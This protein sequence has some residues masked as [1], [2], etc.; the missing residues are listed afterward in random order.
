MV[1]FFILIN[2]LQM[3]KNKS[4]GVTNTVYFVR[5]FGFS[6]IYFNFGDIYGK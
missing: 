6:I 3:Y 2:I 1:E 5:F 4:R